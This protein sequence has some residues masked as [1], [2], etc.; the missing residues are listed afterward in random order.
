MKRFALGVAFLA[1]VSAAS[2]ALADDYRIGVIHDGQLKMTGTMDELRA[3]T[4][5]QRLR[6]IFRNL[7]GLPADV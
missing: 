2:P 3:A 6:E 5:K 4:G 1:S 7:L